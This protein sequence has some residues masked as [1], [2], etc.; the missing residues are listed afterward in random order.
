MPQELKQNSVNTFVRGLITEATPLTFPEGASVDE[1]N[2]ELRRTGRRDRRKGIEFETGFSLSS[3]TFTK[4][5]LVHSLTW[6]NV[7]SLAG[8][9]FEVVQVGDTLYFYDKSTSPVSGNE[10]SFTVNLNTFSAGNGKIIAE[11]RI[12]GDSVNGNF[13][14][15]SAAIESFFIEFDNDTDTIVTTQIN[16]KIRDFEWQGDT[17][18]YAD[19]ISAGLVSDERKYDSYSAGWV[20][21]N[22]AGDDV[23]F[24]SDEG[25]VTRT[26]SWPALNIPWF[27]S[28]LSD[29]RFSFGSFGK[30]SGGNGLIGNGHFILDLYSKDRA[31]AS[32]VASIPTETESGRFSSMTGYAG[33][34]WFSGLDSS[35]NGSRIYFTPVLEG[36]S[37]IGAFHQEA[38]PTA[39]DISD[40]TDADGGVVN[41]PAA[42][43]IRAL[44]EWSSSLLVFAENGVWEIRG[45]DG[46]FK[47]T[48]FSVSR[49]GGAS[50]IV[51]SSTLVD[52]EGIPF[53]W[54]REGI[55]TLTPNTDLTSATNTQGTNIS[56]ATVQSFW[57]AIPGNQRQDA[58]GNYDAINN[59]VFWLYGND[60]ATQFKYN[61]VLILDIPLQAF[62]PWTFVDES[63][64]TNYAVGLSYFSGL[65][66]QEV[67]EDVT[68]SAVTVT[69]SS[70]TVTDTTTVSIE[71]GTTEIKFLVRDGDTGS[72]SFATMTNTGFLDWSTEDF[73]SFAEAGY[74]FED[75]M[76]TYKHGVYVT[77]YFDLT[78]TGFTGNE[79]AGYDPI[80][81]SS[82]LLKAHW[83]LK[84][85]ASSSQEAYRLLRP[86]VVDTGDL[87]VF[88]YPFSVVKTRNRIRGRGTNLKLRFESTTGKDFRLQGYEVI[89]AK[90]QGL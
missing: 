82:C 26:G 11:E 12:A 7:S 75:D 39:E 21:K 18:T 1:N 33:R 83:D 53:W 44:F 29:G 6:E 8:V 63:S 64:N 41:I 35:K 51:N 79:T 14:V 34:G 30:I 5:T 87:T 22:D 13:I 45:I 10:K 4:G 38:D 78:E 43:K 19:K 48:E 57:E 67:T 61:K 84:V 27:S 17:T 85:A 55:Y 86:V 3:F 76:T 59:R 32:G 49:I 50:G 52:A 66:A 37:K 28:K 40:L 80:G 42:S 73:T 46:I 81:Q 72:L 47:A 31:T 24:G 20:D 74:D 90:N 77:T 60:S 58:V 36:M 56:L 23:L 70:V 62:V 2:C 54:G 88:N 65:G 68:D 89:N 9:E 69:D 71:V 15:V 16:P 25:Y